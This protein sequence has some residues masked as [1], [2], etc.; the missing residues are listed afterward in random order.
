VAVT[1]IGPSGPVISASL[2]V[3]C[4][5]SKLKKE[6]AT[7]KLQSAEKALVNDKTV[8]SE[9][10]IAS[11]KLVEKR[12][13]KQAEKPVT[14]KSVGLDKGV[15]EKFV[16]NKLADRPGIGTG[17][18]GTQ[19]SSLEARIANIEAMLM[20]GQAAQAFI[21]RDLRPDLSDSAYAEEDSEADPDSSS[22]KRLLDRP[23][24]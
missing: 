11:E 14:D 3:K 18:G 19:L 17:L 4:T 8:A 1:G 5:V 2:R 20:G 7:D 24:G 9:K 23:Q 21:S 13:E 22:G 15:G 6:V 10:S 12:I 16:E